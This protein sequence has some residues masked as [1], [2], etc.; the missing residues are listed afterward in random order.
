VVIKAET[1]L[2]KARRDI[3]YNP[4]NLG[5]HHQN[6]GKFSAPLGMFGFSIL[7][8]QGKILS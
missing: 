7:E 4:T 8:V 1:V 3:T 6:A 2:R 5:T